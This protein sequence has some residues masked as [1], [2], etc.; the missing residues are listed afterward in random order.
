MVVPPKIIHLNGMF[1]AIQQ[2]CFFGIPH[3]RKANAYSTIV[4]RLKKRKHEGFQS[5]KHSLPR[6]HPPD[7]AQL[8]PGLHLS[9][10]TLP[11]VPP[12]FGGEEFLVPTDSW[13]YEI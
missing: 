6:C 8:R 10:C 13:K 4:I 7:P 5:I 12:C 1:H 3:F 11:P 2:P 9:G